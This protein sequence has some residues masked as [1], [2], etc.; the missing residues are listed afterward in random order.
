[1]ASRFIGLTVEHTGFSP[2][3]WKFARDAKASSTTFAGRHNAFWQGTYLDRL[4]ELVS[5]ESVTGAIPDAFVWYMF[6]WLGLELN[7]ARTEPIRDWKLSAWF[8]T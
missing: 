8:G 2:A 7:A 1:M 6:N 5:F 3:G 4:V